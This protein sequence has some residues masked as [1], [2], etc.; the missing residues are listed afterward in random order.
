[1]DRAPEKQPADIHEGI[2]NTLT[3]LNHKIKKSQIEVE[4]SYQIS[5]NVDIFISEMNQVWTNL[6]DNA[7]DA[8]E[9]SPEKKL[10]I[11]TWD[12]GEFVNID[13]KDSGAGIPEEMIENIFDP[14]F[15]TKAVGKG[16]GLGLDVAR[17]IIIQH[18][19]RIKVTSTPGETIFNVC[20]PRN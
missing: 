12:D 5:G 1:M 9:A 2:N 17:Q 7:I 8:M 20:I 10:T 15:T 18:N 3:M 16:T 13:I 4:Q 11:N 6:I 14:F 19:G